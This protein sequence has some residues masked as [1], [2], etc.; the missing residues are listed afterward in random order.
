MNRLA[1]AAK[2]KYMAQIDEAVATLDIY[3]NGSVGIGEH[4]DLLAEV[5]KYID[6]LSTAQDKLATLDRLLKVPE[7]PKNVDQ[8][9]E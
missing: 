5:D 3:L 6:L 9:A 8:T 1:Q 2:S 7:Q 4:S